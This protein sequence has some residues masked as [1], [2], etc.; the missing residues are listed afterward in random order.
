[1]QLQFVKILIAQARVMGLEAR[2]PQLVHVLRQFGPDEA[3]ERYRS[4]ALM[5]PDAQPAIAQYAVGMVPGVAG[6]ELRKA[7]LFVEA[8]RGGD[9]AGGQTH[10]QEAA[11]H[12]QAAGPACART[13]LHRACA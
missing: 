9:V 10:F 4:G 11:E 2:R 6:G 1:M 5:Q 7:Q 3:Q 8:D 13:R 12:V